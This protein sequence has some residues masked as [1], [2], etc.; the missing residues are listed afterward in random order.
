[1]DTNIDSNLRPLMQYSAPI[2]K[3]ITTEQQA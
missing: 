2:S 3:Y 1:M